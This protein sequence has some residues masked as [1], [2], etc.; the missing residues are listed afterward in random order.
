[1]NHNKEKGITTM[2]K[3]NLIMIATS[4]VFLLSAVFGKEMHTTRSQH[5]AR[6]AEGLE[7]QSPSISV[8]NINNTCMEVHLKHAVKLSQE[9]TVYAFF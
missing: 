2:K 9:V 7:N 5:V 4:A 3:K 6:V 8:M 1:M